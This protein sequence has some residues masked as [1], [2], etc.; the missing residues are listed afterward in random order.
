MHS[1]LKKCSSI[2]GLDWSHHAPS[3][4]QLMS[5]IDLIH[6]MLHEQAGVNTLILVTP[7]HGLAVDLI[8]LKPLHYPHS[9]LKFF[10]L[11]RSN[12]FASR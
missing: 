4:T 5:L 10:F 7:S 12:C 9:C 8:G 2:G 6:K 3:I 1:F 11:I